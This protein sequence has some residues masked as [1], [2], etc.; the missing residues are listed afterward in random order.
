MI[1]AKRLRSG[2]TLVELLVVMTIFVSVTVVISGIFL[3]TRRQERATLARQEVAN[4]L[5]FVTT[6]LTRQIS[7]SAIAYGSWL[8][9]DTHQP[10]TELQLLPFESVDEVIIRQ[11]DTR[12]EISYSGGQS[13]E[14]LTDSTITI[15]TVAFY[16]EPRVDPSLITAG[17]Y[18][19]DQQPIVTIVISGYSAAPSA[20]NQPPLVIQTSVSSR[21]YQR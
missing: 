18:A 17:Q 16:V 15:D 8:P 1:G 21:L 14:D 4:S 6:Y 12:L 9:D 13:W 11:T 7:R 19:A 20:V 2:F 5:Q 3:L 10:T